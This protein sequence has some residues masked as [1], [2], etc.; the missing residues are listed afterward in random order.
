MTEADIRTLWTRYMHR[1]DIASDLDAVLSF[2]KERV[3]ERLL[4]TVV[5]PDEILASSP[6]SIFHAGMTYL[7][8]LLQDDEQL[9]RETSLMET[10]VQ[11]YS[12]RRAIDKGPALMGASNGT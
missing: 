12:F 10:A 1:N 6:R 2:A 4:F 11:D 7:A 5:D 8:E 3:Q 9:M